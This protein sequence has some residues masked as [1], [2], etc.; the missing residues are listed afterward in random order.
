MPFWPLLLMAGK[1]FINNTSGSTIKLITGLFE[2]LVQ[3]QAKSLF[4][5]TSSK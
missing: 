5:P 2:Q 3:N 1:Q 4:C